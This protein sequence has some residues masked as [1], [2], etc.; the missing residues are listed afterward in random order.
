MRQQELAVPPAE[1]QPRKPGGPTAFDSEVV[2]VVAERKQNS[3]RTRYRW[4]SGESHPA[5]RRLEVRSCP[6]A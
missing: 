3:E 2:D 6:F 4:S 5:K 1:T